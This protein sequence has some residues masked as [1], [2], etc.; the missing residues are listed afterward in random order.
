[1][2]V[3]NSVFILSSVFV[4]ISLT[5]TWKLRSHKCVPSN[6]IIE[7]ILTLQRRPAH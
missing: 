5:L 6:N 4:G 2:L 1:M 7:T 3:V